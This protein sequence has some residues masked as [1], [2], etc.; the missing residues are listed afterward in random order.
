MKTIEQLASLSTDTD[1]YSGFFP[2]SKEAGS[3][4]WPRNLLRS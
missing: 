2:G 1:S 3:W 4:S